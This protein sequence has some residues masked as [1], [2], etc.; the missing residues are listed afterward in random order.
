V[1]YGIGKGYIKSNNPGY[2]GPHPTM[3]WDNSEN[4]IS[5]M[6]HTPYYYPSAHEMYY[7]YSQGYPQGYMYPEG[8]HPQGGRM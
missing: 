1:I 7:F 8:H 4:Y 3:Y 6:A 2:S 5:H